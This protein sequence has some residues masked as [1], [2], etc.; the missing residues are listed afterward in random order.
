MI[1]KNTGVPDSELWDEVKKAIQPLG[2][3]K[4]LKSKPRLIQPTKTIIHPVQ[5]N[6]SVNYITPK[7]RPS[8]QP[9]AI[10][11]F[12]RRT[13]QRLGRGNVEPDSR[14]D[15]HGENLES[16]RYALLNFIAR[17]RQTGNRLVLVIT[18]KGSSPFAR[19]TLHGHS[20]FNTPEREGKLRREV[21]MW[22]HDAEFRTHIVGFQPSHP[23]HGGGGAF[24]VKLRRRMGE[25][26]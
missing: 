14:I 3:R 13:A 10:S 4:T 7:I 18:G 8:N 23:R 12:D 17:Q 6:D 19:H 15:L 5:N 20:H 22:F 24:Y 25:I 11:A 2:R 21:P 16:A 26:E 1:K 9:P